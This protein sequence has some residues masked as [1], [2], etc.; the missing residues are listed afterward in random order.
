MEING[1]TVNDQIKYTE[2]GLSDAVLRAI[3]KKGYVM[4]T[5]VQAGRFLL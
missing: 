2:L 4:A 5:P 3:E 1:Q